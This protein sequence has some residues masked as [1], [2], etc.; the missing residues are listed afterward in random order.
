[1][2]THWIAAALLSSTL[3]TACGAGVEN[4]NSS[5]EPALTPAAEPAPAPQAASS[6]AAPGRPQP[7]STNAARRPRPAPAP[8]ASAPAAAARPRFR[9]VSAPAGTELPLELTTALSTETAQVE[10]P[11]TA[12]LRRSV[13]VDGLTVFPAG[14]VFHGNVT[15]AERAGRVRG[16]SHL[17]LRFTEVEIQGQRDQARTN[18]VSFEG[19]AT[20]S[21]DATKV[22]AGAGIGAV[23]GGIVG[24]GSGAAK[25]AAIGGAAGAGAVLA[26]RGR[27]VELPV[28]TE[29]A[30]TLSSP[31]EVRVEVQ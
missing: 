12:R 29:V 17:A 31:F 1:M 3:A 14:A 24:G 28:G 20:K 25:G 19:E 15:E 5:T 23:I 2:K 22:G 27:D 8:A 7:S 16:R 21:E 18:V 26:T 30:A 11:V 6:T 9:E 4:A 13:V 10:T